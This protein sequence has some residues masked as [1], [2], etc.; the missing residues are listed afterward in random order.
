MSK[1]K[2]YEQFNENNINDLFRSLHAAVDKK[3]LIPIAK[4]VG[5]SNMPTHE[6]VDFATE[7]LN[8]EAKDL[9]YDP[10]GM[11]QN[12][13][14][15][16]GPFFYPFFGG[17]KREM[18]EM[19]H[20]D[21]NFERKQKQYA[22]LLANKDYVSLFN[23]VDKKALI[24]VYM[25]M[26]DEIPDSQKYDTFIELYV[27][28]EFGFEMFPMNFLKDVF[29]KRKLSSEWKK[30]MDKFKKE[31]KNAEE[32]TI[33]RGVGSKSTQ[34]GMS[35]TLSKKTAKFFADRFGQKGKVMEKTVKASDVLDYLD[36]R[37]ESEVLIFAS[38]A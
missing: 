8:I 5:K 17:L 38:K 18:L 23:H 15:W 22:E 27:R 24:P 31:T 4:V 29:S 37:G 19:I 25:E 10:N 7:F 13:V 1:F 36:N 20:L 16:K 33:Y 3:S 32:V 21:K 14:Y 28:S 2:T 34:D 35:W 30:S 9:Y 12:I 26:Y 6:E 11:V